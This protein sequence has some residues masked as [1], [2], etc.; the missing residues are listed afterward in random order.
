MI[1]TSNVRPGNVGNEEEANFE[2]DSKDEDFDYGS[3][4]E[5]KDDLEHDLGG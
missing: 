2:E 4:K 1:S 3:K 5:E